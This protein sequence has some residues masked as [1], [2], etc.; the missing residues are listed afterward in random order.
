VLLDLADQQ[1]EVVPSRQGDLAEAIGELLDD[2]E[3][4]RTD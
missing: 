1:I 3:G 4:L 2:L